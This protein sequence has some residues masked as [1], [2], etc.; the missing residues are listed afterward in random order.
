VAG[1]LAELKNLWYF[2]TGDSKANAASALVTALLSAAKALKAAFSG[3]LSAYAKFIPFIGIP[4]AVL[5]TLWIWRSQIVPLKRMDEEHTKRITALREAGKTPADITPYETLQ[6]QIRYELGWAKWNAFLAGTTLITQVV[7]VVTGP[8][9]WIGTGLMLGIQVVS[10]AAKFL[11]DAWR[12]HKAAKAEAYEQDRSE[13]LN[14]RE[15]QLAEIT[16]PQSG[17]TEEDRRK[18]ITQ[19]RDALEAHDIARQQMLEKSNHAAFLDI[20]RQAFAP[21]A[22]GETDSLDQETFDFLSSYGLTRTTIKHCELNAKDGDDLPI[23]AAIDDLKTFLAVGEPRT[24]PSRAVA[25]IGAMTRF[26]GRRIRRAFGTIEPEDLSSRAKLNFLVMKKFEPVGDFVKRA[27]SL[28]KP[29]D[30]TQHLALNKMIYDPAGTKGCAFELARRLQDGIG[31]RN[32][33]ELATILGWAGEEVRF[34]LQRKVDM[35]IR[36]NLL[37]EGYNTANPFAEFVREGD[38]ITPIA[39]LNI[40][41]IDS[42]PRRQRMRLEANRGGDPMAPAT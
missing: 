14:L 15:Q 24:I 1:L 7:G 11:I 10:A 17:A 41:R 36:A 18:A 28:G 38:A 32:E 37:P 20:L 42:G 5:E 23:S 9:G 30:D 22:N 3:P 35:L 29:L 27:V 8:L 40:G 2:V 21:V 12:Q 25:A 16:D 6:H 26:V 19:Y 33:D 34:Y 31:K 13:E 4:V 39:R